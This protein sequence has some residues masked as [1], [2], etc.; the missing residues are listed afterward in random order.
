[1]VHSPRLDLTP[2]P[3]VTGVSY[4]PRWGLFFSYPPVYRPNMDRDDKR[5]MPL[6]NN[7]IMAAL[8]EKQ[9][10]PMVYVPPVING[11]KSVVDANA[12]P[13]QVRAQVIRIHQEADPIAFL[14]SVQRGDI[15]YE[16]YI[17]GKGELHTKP[18]TPS[19]KHRILAAKYL[20]DKVMPRL[21]VVKHI[22]D[23][24]D[25]D[26]EKKDNRSF[27]KVV[28]AVGRRINE[29][30][31]GRPPMLDVTPGKDEPA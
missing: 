31:P 27:D 30:K 25:G 2:E 5:N 24:G 13:P 6:F 20:A 3:P 15:F 16:Y 21:G 4:P 28:E 9:P 18:I 11:K 19:M 1:M 10:P 17:D 12:K 8:Q 14:M 7:A 26:G 22:V 23:S 29:R